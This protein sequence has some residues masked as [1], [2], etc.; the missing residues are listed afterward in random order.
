MSEKNISKWYVA[1]GQND[2]GNYISIKEE[3]TDLIA[4]YFDGLSKELSNRM[5]GDLEVM[6]KKHNE[7]VKKLRKK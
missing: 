3:D 2:L 5:I 7:L 6:V 1:Q 4:S